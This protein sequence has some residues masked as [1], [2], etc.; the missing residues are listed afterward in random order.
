MKIFLCPFSL[1]LTEERHL[2][3]HGE[4]M[5]TIGKVSGGYCPGGL[6]RDSFARNHLRCV[7]RP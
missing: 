4:R 7:E 2:S 1:S 3:V 5:G 6:P